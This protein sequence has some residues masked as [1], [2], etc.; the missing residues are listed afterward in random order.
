MRKTQKE[1]ANEKIFAIYK[2]VRYELCYIGRT[3]WGMKAL[4]YQ[5]A[6]RKFW[7]DAGLVQI[8]K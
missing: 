1:I 5:S 2:K 7:V 4:L 3:K 8:V 6:K